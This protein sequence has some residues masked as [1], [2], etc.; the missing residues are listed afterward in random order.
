MK[1][2]RVTEKEEKEEEEETFLKRICKGIH[3]CMFFFFLFFSTWW[4]WFVL[5]YWDWLQL[6]GMATREDDEKNEE[7]FD[8]LELVNPRRNDCMFAY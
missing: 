6:V 7:I 1:R 5:T 2:K 3:G 4:I 8:E